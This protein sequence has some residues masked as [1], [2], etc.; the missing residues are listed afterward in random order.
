MKNLKIGDIII[1]CLILAL[2]AGV[3]CFRFFGTESGQNA[4]ITVGGQSKIYSL[5]ENREIEIDNNNVS[6]VV[7]IE[8]GSVYIKESTCRGNNCV[9]LGKISNSN[10]TIVCAPAELIVEIIG[11]G[12]DEYEYDYVIG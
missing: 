4:V 12:A 1:I 11:K 3:F 10:K 5:N 7:V 9:H 6:L 8:N 2:S